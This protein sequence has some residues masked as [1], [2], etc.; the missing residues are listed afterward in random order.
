MLADATQTSTDAATDLSAGDRA[1]SL[2]GDRAARAGAA[3]AG[4]PAGLMGRLV[5]S[6]VVACIFA[7]PAIAILMQTGG[8][9]QG[10]PSMDS[11]VM[12]SAMLGTLGVLL[13][14]ACGLVM[15]SIFTSRGGPS[16][17]MG[18]LACSGIRLLGSVAIAFGLS[19]LIEV[20]SKPFWFSLLLAGGIAL[21]LETM[22]VMKSLGRAPSAALGSTR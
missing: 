7:P 2:A 22:L 17:S 16:V 13:G 3:G 1:A 19:R 14:G 18:F 11:P 10:L 12:V 20:E 8:A 15:L 21:V 4:L 9:S 6:L 5:A